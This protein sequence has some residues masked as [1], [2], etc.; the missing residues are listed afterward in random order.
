MR[1]EQFWNRVSQNENECWEWI[2]ALTENGYGKA[3]FEK[4]MR[5]A[6]RIAALLSGKLSA[7]DC[8]LVVMHQCNNR[9]CINPRHLEVGSQ[10]E[11]V[12]HAILTGRFKPKAPTYEGKVSEQDK[13]QIRQ[14]F[15]NK[16]PVSKLCAKF[17]LSRSTIYRIVSD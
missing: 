15:Q 13:Q 17:Q 4:K 16:T 14:E 5:Y 11:N 2:G 6:H 8:T 7:L 3:R 12:R 10:S 1:Q 9:K